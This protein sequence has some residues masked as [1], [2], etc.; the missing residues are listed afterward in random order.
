MSQV[1]PVVGTTNSVLPPSHPDVDLNVPGQVCPVVGAKTDHHSN[2]SK[3]PSVPLPADAQNDTISSADAQKCPALK[4]AIEQP[5]AKELDDQVCPV[6]G[7]ATT[8]L[9]PDHPSTEG[10][11]DDAECPVTKAKIGHHKGKVMQHPDVSSAAEGAVCP[12]V[13]ARG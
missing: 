8:I 3:H 6:I 1:C 11:G 10:K 9:P 7:P 2:L 4:T 12:V 13:G 5:K